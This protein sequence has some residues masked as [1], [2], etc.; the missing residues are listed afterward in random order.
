MTERIYGVANKWKEQ[1][2]HYQSLKEKSLRLLEHPDATEA[3]LLELARILRETRRDMY[4]MKDRLNS[5]FPKYSFDLTGKVQPK[6]H[7]KYMPRIAIQ[8]TPT[9]V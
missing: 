9:T 3:H 2:A 7:T 1:C 5:S 4:D 6:N 8:S